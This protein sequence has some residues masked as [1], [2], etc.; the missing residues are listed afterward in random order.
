[1]SIFEMNI[2]EMGSQVLFG[3][4]RAMGVLSQLFWDRALLLPL[5]RPKSITSGWIKAQFEK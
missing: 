5:E 1:M 2:S 3:V 4:S